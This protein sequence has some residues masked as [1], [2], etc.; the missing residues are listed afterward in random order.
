MIGSIDDRIRYK[1]T[2]YYGGGGTANYNYYG[3][4]GNPAAPSYHQEDFPMGSFRENNLFG[5]HHHIPG[6]YHKH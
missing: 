4:S 3:G 2:G 1:R 6:G 5:G